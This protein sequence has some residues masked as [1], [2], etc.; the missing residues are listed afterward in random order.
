MIM[1][2]NSTTN[3]VLAAIGGFV[4]FRYLKKNCEKASISIRD[5]TLKYDRFDWC[6]GK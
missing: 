5:K 2:N 4:L 1:I 6:F 3:D